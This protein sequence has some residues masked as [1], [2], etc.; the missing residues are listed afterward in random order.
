MKTTLEIPD[1]IFRE[2]KILAAREGLTLT[3]IVT[4]ALRSTLEK[5]TDGDRGR[6]PTRKRDQGRVGEWTDTEANILESM[7][8]GASGTELSGNTALEVMADL[9]RTLDDATGE[10]LA[11]AV[12]VTRKKTGNRGLRNPW[13]S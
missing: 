6:R 13:A 5:Q 7:R 8:G 12:R 4:A 11:R 1:A 9:Y 3:S 10:A 2:L